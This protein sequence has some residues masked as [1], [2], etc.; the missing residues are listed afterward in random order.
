MKVTRE[1]CHD[2]GGIIN[3][4]L[5]WTEKVYIRKTVSSQQN[6]IWDPGRMQKANMQNQGKKTTR[7]IKRTTTE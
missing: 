5:L 3:H 4:M 2:I 7:R 1:C 6:K